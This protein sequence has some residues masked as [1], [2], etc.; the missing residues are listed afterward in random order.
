MYSDRT[1][2]TCCRPLPGSHPYSVFSKKISASSAALSSHTWG[3]EQPSLCILNGRQHYS[4]HTC[5]HK[6]RYLYIYT[7]VSTF[8]LLSKDHLCKIS[9]IPNLYGSFLG[10]G[11]LLLLTVSREFWVERMP[12]FL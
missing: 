5:K 3:M 4:F 12:R 10:S 2:Q 6:V 11:T 1:I 9:R 8:S 7:Q